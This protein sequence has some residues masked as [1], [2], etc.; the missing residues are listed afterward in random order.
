MIK[1][2]EQILAEMSSH[3]TPL[4]TLQNE[5]ASNPN[6]LSKGALEKCAAAHAN[7]AKF[8]RET[9]AKLPADKDDPNELSVS[10]TNADNAVSNFSRSIQA[11][12]AKPTAPQRSEETSARARTEPREPAHDST[13]PLSE[14]IKGLT[15]KQQVVADKLDLCKTDLTRCLLNVPDCPKQPDEWNKSLCSWG[16]AEK[17]LNKATPEDFLAKT[18]ASLQAF[19]SFAQLMNNAAE[20]AEGR[21]SPAFIETVK[22]FNEDLNETRKYFESV[23]QITI[24]QSVGTDSSAPPS[25]GTKP[26][27]RTTNPSDAGESRVTDHSV[28]EEFKKFGVDHVER[29]TYPEGEITVGYKDGKHVA[30]MGGGL[31]VNLEAD[32]STST[33]WR[34]QII[35]TRG[36]WVV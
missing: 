17:A 26:P 6:Q 7:F 28:P 35:Q 30:T 29:E 20:T 31:Y 22:I 12:S 24:S 9:A 21:N 27:E 11:A 14:R 23:Q 2:Y 3:Y 25:D 19:Q 13:L 10:L 16:E 5:I 8:M 15:T 32:R 4:G 34:C 36:G 33:C 1:Q 18:E